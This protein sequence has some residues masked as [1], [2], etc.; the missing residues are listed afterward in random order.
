ML[1][2]IFLYEIQQFL[3]FSMIFASVTAFRGNILANFSFQ[4]EDRTL[5]DF[6]ERDRKVWLRD[7]LF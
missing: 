1:A 2:A 7:K 3:T 4:E 6:S 5:L